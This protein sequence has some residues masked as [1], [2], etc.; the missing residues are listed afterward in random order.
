MSD[1]TPREQ[2]PQISER[3]D[4]QSQ[5][6]RSQLQQQRPQYVPNGNAGVVFDSWRA[7][8]SPFLPLLQP[9]LS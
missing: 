6:L 8:G 7:Q 2:Q 3:Q 9:L 4:Q 1:L 5:Q